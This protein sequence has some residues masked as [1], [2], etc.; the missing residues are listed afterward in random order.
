[1]SLFNVN[2]SLGYYFIKSYVLFR[3]TFNKKLKG[4]GFNITIDHWIVLVVIHNQ[5]GIS[6]TDIS[7]YSLRD[8]SSITRL[9]DYLEKENFII[10]KTDKND[11]RSFNIFLTEQ[12]E[13]LF[14]TVY[15]IAEKIDNQIFADIDTKEIE[16]LKETFRTVISHI[17]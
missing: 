12:G 15:K 9:L 14:Q 11:R 3:E 1:M 16:R 17:K 7:K 5:P 13:S 8:K 6:Q 4:D 2:D 10:R